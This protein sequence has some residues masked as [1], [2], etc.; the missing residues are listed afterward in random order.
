MDVGSFVTAG[1][2]ITQFLEL[3]PL[4]V[5]VNIS[6]NFANDVDRSGHAIVQIDGEE[7]DAKIE[8]I[9]QL[10]DANTRTFA[11]EVVLDNPDRKYSAG[12]T[13]I[14]LLP[15]Q[16]VKAHL[17]SPAYIAIDED[18][19]FGIKTVEDGNKVK[20]YAATLVEDTTEGMW[21]GSV[22]DEINLITQGAAYV[23]P[24][25]EVSAYQSQEE[26]HQAVLAHEQAQKAEE[27]DKTEAKGE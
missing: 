12:Q 5:V 10:A 8:N 2:P 11:V 16:K 27:A 23:S 22:P 21:I 26:A 4:K 7:V 9:S 6:E 13:A 1:T 24:G 18:G 20:F 15:V 19:R 25:Q 17:I 3:N 14:V